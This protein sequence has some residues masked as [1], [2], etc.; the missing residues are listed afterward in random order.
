MSLEF[1]CRLGFALCQSLLLGMEAVLRHPHSTS[2]TTQ[3]SIAALLSV[4]LKQL[5]NL[6]VAGHAWWRACHSAVEAS[7]ATVTKG[8][9]N[10]LVMDAVEPPLLQ[11]NAIFKAAGNLAAVV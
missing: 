7:Q 2:P 4:T 6:V 9:P 8:P 5:T 11:N 10:F 3:H 1:L